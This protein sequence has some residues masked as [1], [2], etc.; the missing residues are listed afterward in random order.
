MD[1]R[2]MFDGSTIIPFSCS[3]VRLGIAAWQSQRGSMPTFNVIRYCRYRT[4][5]RNSFAQREMNGN[6]KLRIIYFYYIS[7]F[8]LHPSYFPFLNRVRCLMSLPH[9]LLN[10]INVNQ[11]DDDDNDDYDYS[12]FETLWKV[13]GERWWRNKHL[14]V[15]LL[16]FPFSIRFSTS[17]WTQSPIVTASHY[18]K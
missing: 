2:N 13:K 15:A 8:F 10:D 4:L 11:R 14:P 17:V 6:E 9:N 18:P 1:T 16:S 7:A 3:R 5:P 12:R